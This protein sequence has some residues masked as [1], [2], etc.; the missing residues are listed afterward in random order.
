MARREMA[1]TTKGE[2]TRAA[3]LETALELFLEHG[4]EGTTM[5]AVAEKA[6]VSLGNAYYYF[7]SKEHLIQAFYARMHAQHL[8]ASADIL[9]GEKDFRQRLRQVMRARIDSIMPY[10]RFAGVLFR[11][12]ADPRSP[13]NPFSDASRPVREESTA[14][15][16][17]VVRGSSLRVQ[18][19]LAGELPGLL[20]L[21]QMAIVLFWI[22]DTSPDC[23]RS[24]K[25]AEQTADL[26]VGL[27]HLARLPPMRP[28]VRSALAL[29]AEMRGDEPEG[30]EAKP[31]GSD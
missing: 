16:A 14:L 29:L 31:A 23:R 6:G 3:I 20:W 7:E 1:K 25:L 22:H 9:K 26:V 27:I 2:R 19:S 13:L 10:H 4:Y 17:E 12:A 8:R 30:A 18:S 24:Y 5:R 11:S 15:F 21:Y 28:V